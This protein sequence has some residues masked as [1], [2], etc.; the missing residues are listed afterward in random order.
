MPTGDGSTSGQPDDGTV[1]DDAT[2]DDSQGTDSD[3]PADD[4][5]SVS[6]P[7][8]V[9]QI[10]LGPTPADGNAN[11]PF[12]Q[13]RE[14]PNCGMPTN[15]NNDDVMA[16]Y[17]AWRAATVT[18]SGAGDNA[19]RIQRLPSDP[20]IANET[21]DTVSE[22]IAYGLLIAVYMNDQDLFD[23]LWRYE[24]RFLDAQGLMHWHINAAG[25]E[26]VGQG[27]ASDADED[28]AWA[29][30][31]A[32]RQWGGG[33]TLGGNYIDIA[34]D[35]IDKMWAHE[36]LDG[37]LFLP[38]DQF[39]DWGTINVSY[40]TPNYFRLFG[41]VS[42]NPGWNDVVVTS[43]DALEATMKPE[44]G[45]QDNG[46]VPAWSAADGTPNGGAWGPDRMSPTHHQYDSCRTPF[47]I[48]LDYCFNA[49]PRS[50]SYV[51]KITSFYAGLSVDGMT[52]GYDLNGQAR[53]Q[54]GGL[55]AAFVGPAAVGAMS[56][57][58]LYQQ[59]L[60]DAYDRLKTLNLLVGGEYYDRSWTVI[61]LLMLTG[62]FLDYTKIEP[63]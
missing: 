28:M 60:D 41:E 54:F 3:D 49:E 9:P 15:I 39:G 6:E 40:F 35:L 46:L 17:E 62:N 29:M 1:G 25:T 30:I 59:F 12:P 55:S 19:Y 10:P 37:K 24:Q 8:V 44:Y 61:S 11:F 56:D 4:Q 23:G 57:P 22:G 38:G 27:A 43:Y 13:N 2:S 47:R 31:M 58:A 5:G 32:D 34:R 21:N 20:M 16:A 26:V 53:P 50:K 48:G 14:L 51:D 42:G 18:T 45:N 63:L 33:G 7:E 52:D 36:V